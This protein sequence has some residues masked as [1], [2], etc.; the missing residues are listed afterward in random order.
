MSAHLTKLSIHLRLA[1][2]TCPNLR[3]LD[4]DLSLHWT[5]RD[6]DY[7]LGMMK[8][9]YRT[10]KAPDWEGHTEDTWG[11]DMALFSNLRTFQLYTTA[12]TSHLSALAR[13][14]HCAKAWRFPVGDEAELQFDRIIE[15]YVFPD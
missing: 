4:P 11:A 7:S 14:V 1:S 15:S 8:A 6:N 3:G 13:V 2:F 10:R 12:Y 5:T 9:Q